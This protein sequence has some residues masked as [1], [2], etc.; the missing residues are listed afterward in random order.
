MQIQRIYCLKAIDQIVCK[1]FFLNKKKFPAICEIRA[2]CDSGEAN[3]TALRWS[4]FSKT[5]DSKES[6]VTGSYLSD[7]FSEDSST[8]LDLVNPCNHFEFCS[9]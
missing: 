5:E 9:K 2:F 8:E 1:I 7:E 6:N 4:L 3:K